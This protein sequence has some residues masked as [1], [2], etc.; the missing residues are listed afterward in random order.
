[1]GDGF[2]YL[3]WKFLRKKRSRAHT[4]AVLYP[5]SDMWNAEAEEIVNLDGKNSTKSQLSTNPAVCLM[6][7]TSNSQSRTSV[8]TLRNLVFTYVLVGAFKCQLG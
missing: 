7:I 1:M 8:L 3:A 4:W 6:K 2:S 5:T